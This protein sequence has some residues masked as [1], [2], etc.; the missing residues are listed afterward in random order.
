[1]AEQPLE[2]QA[3][4][5]EE[6]R[7]NPNQTVRNA[8]RK[9]KGYKA[10]FLSNQE[11]LK[12]ESTS[13]P[14]VTP[15][16]NGETVTPSLLQ[17]ALD[18]QTQ[19]QELMASG[20]PSSEWMALL[21]EGLALKVQAEGAQGTDM[22]GAGGTSD[23]VDQGI[24]SAPVLEQGTPIEPTGVSI[25]EQIQKSIQENEILLKAVAKTVLS[26]N[27]ILTEIDDSDAISLNDYTLK[28]L[29]RIRGYISQGVL[30]VK[31]SIEDKLEKELKG[32]RVYWLKKI[33][34]DE[35]EKLEFK[36]TF[37]TP[38]PTNDQNRIIDGLEKQLKRTQSEENILKI[39]SKINELK[40]LSKSI[41]GIDKIIIHS[42]LKTICAFTNTIGGHLLLGVSDD[43]KIFGLE[44]DYNSFKND[45]NRDGFAKFFD[46]IIKD[47]FGDSFSSSLLEKEFLKFPKGDILI[48][49]VKK[50]AEE[51][52][53]L[54][55]EKGVKEESIYIRN[56]SSSNKLKGIE[57]SKFIKNKFREQIVDKSE[58]K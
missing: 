31:E 20:A 12:K 2:F 54:K 32:K 39:N 11:A 18:K 47:Y 44:Q 34:E 17:Q 29:K 45:E 49:K 46:S 37:I 30:S 23:P 8:Q 3:F 19:A 1:M 38:I 35:G 50:S 27:L 28:N 6:L 55:N 5:E 57:L 42:A 43:K 41:T 10:D 33:N 25:Q 40:G 14:V 21:R 16:S 48:V 13:V 51:V 26:N 22:T 53:L 58:I 9:Y 15:P 56:L 24:G 52:F 4:V 7:K 36:A